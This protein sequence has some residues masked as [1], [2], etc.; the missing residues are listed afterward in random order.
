MSDRKQG[1]L[2]FDWALVFYWMTATTSGWLFGWLLWPP[3]ALVTAGVLAGA[4]QCAVLVRRIPKAWRWMLVTASGWL[5]GTAMVLIAAGSGAFAGLAIGAFTGTAQWVLLRREVQW[6]GWWIAISA[7]AWSVGLSLAPS[8]EA[9]LL[10]RVVLS[11]VMPSLIT[12]ITLELLLR[13]PRPAAEA[14]ED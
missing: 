4:V 5:A 1:L 7:V 12:G 9:V 10:P 2:E 3:I 8:P 6:A 11:G 14:E 13:H